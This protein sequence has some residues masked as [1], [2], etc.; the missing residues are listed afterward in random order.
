MRRWASG[1]LALALLAATPA[2]ASRP[3]GIHISGTRSSSSWLEVDVEGPVPFIVEGRVVSRLSKVLV[4]ADRVDD[5]P[6]TKQT[7]RF[8]GFR[9]HRDFRFALRAKATDGTTWKSGWKEG[10][11][12][13]GATTPG[14]SGAPWGRRFPGLHPP[15]IPDDWRP[16]LAPMAPPPGQA[17]GADDSPLVRRARTL[18]EPVFARQDGVELESLK[19][20]TGGRVQARGV[21]RP[22]QAGPALFGI[23]RVKA[24]LKKHAAGLKDVKVR[25]IEDLEPKHYKAKSFVVGFEMP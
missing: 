15:S 11:V 19:V 12:R 24:T 5:E 25:A 22:L 21:S 6:R 9:W 20:T 16:T 23:T 13:A 3:K 14:G 1:G 18:L 2:R 4:A 17:W 10:P 8:A 7:V